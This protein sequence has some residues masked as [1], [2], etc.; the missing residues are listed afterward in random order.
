MAY[1]TRLVASC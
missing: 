1:T